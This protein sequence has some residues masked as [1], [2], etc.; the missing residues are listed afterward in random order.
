[1]FSFPYMVVSVDY[2]STSRNGVASLGSEPT[3]DD[4]DTTDQ[5]WLRALLGLFSAPSNYP[6]IIC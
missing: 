1:M 6:D 4:V 2:R 5:R 3:G